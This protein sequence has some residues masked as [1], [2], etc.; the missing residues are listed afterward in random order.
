MSNKPSGTAQQSPR[1][2]NN[3]RSDA[4]RAPDQSPWVT[5]AKGS[6][7]KPRPNP[8]PREGAPRKPPSQVP[9]AGSGSQIPLWAANPARTGDEAEKHT[10]SSRKGSYVSG[11]SGGTSQGA[12][13]VNNSYASGAVPAVHTAPA[14]MR[15]VKREITAVDEAFKAELRD[16]APDLLLQI[17]SQL[18]ADNLDWWSAE[19]VASPNPG[20]IEGL[21]CSAE[22]LSRYETERAL[23][24]YLSAASGMG[25]EHSIQLEMLRSDTV[26]GLCRKKLFYQLRCTSSQ[27]LNSIMNAEITRSFRGYAITFFQ[28]K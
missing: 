6:K 24:T 13:G 4:R 16:E 11:R 14:P 1:D 17:E 19:M 3:Q 21:T 5:V 15:M 26:E 25:S 28:Q 12:T 23:V 27:G 9:Q 18:A 7:K 8:G 2:Q 10:D 20:W 22:D